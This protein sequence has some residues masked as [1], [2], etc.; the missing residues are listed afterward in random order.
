MT[1]GK[2]DSDH[3]AEEELLFHVFVLAGFIESLDIPLHR[4]PPHRVRFS[5]QEATKDQLLPH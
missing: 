3:K 2:Q 4:I 5:S 1:S